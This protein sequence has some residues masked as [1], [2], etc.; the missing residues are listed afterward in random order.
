[1]TVFVALG[2]AVLIYYPKYRRPVIG[3]L[4][5]LG[6]SLIG[7]DYHFLSDVIG[8]AYLGYTTTCLLN[9]LFKKIRSELD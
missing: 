7:T 6:I 2:I 5:I 8:G 3:F 4:I 9:Y 1:M